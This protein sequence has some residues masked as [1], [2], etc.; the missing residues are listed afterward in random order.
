MKTKLKRQIPINQLIIPTY[1]HYAVEE[2]V[3]DGLV[4]EVNKIIYDVEEIKRV[5]DR[6]TEKVIFQQRFQ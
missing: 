3:E 1:Y 5:F 2:D 4:D 6:K